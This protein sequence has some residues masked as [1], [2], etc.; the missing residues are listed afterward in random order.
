MWW[1]YAEINGNCVSYRDWAPCSQLMPGSS[2]L[3]F[4]VLP[5]RYGVCVSL[6]D[7]SELNPNGLSF[8]DATLSYPIFRSSINVLLA[9]Y[10]PRLDRMYSDEINDVPLILVC[11]L[12]QLWVSRSRSLQ[13]Y[14]QFLHLAPSRMLCRWW[15]HPRWSHALRQNLYMTMISCLSQG[16]ITCIVQL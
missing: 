8:V 15:W 14:S 12:V 9:T 10:C 13:R 2:V 5:Q 6:S 3:V 1:Y 11:S 16:I 4:T 7:S